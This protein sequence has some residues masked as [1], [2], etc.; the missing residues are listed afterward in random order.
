[1]EPMTVAFTF[2]RRLLPVQ[3]PHLTY[4][5]ARNGAKDRR[6]AAY[7]HYTQDTSGNLLLEPAVKVLL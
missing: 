1:M 6:H 3:S 4:G 7:V 5:N 2:F